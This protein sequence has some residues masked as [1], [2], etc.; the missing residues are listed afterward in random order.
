MG[1]GETPR[2]VE[3]SK[4]YMAARELVYDATR[5]LGLNLYYGTR[6]KVFGEYYQKMGV[7]EKGLCVLGFDLRNYQ[8][9]HRTFIWAN[10]VAGSTSFG[11][12]RNLAPSGQLPGRF[13]SS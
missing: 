4:G 11:I 7:S 3:G 5:N 1:K 9:I 8:R 12:R 10:R 2:S 6:Y 13:A